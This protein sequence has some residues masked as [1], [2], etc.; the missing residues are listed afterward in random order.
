MPLFDYLFTYSFVAEKLFFQ[1]SKV[2][3]SYE[4]LY[5]HP[6]FFISVIL[7]FVWLFFMLEKVLAKVTL[8]PFKANMIFFITLNVTTDI[9]HS[10]CK[11]K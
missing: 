3:Y 10:Y 9:L 2:T 11:V 4:K 8:Y 7:I 1:Y 6:K 5:S